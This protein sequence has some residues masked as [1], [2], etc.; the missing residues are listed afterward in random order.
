MAT[1]E[2]KKP[3]AKPKGQKPKAS[4]S[5]EDQIAKLKAE[6]EALRAGKVDKP[7]NY[8]VS[9]LNRKRKHA[10]SYN[11]SP[12]VYNNGD[13]VDP[14]HVEFIQNHVPSIKLEAE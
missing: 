6:N 12:V 8:F 7:L 11:R 1:E 14:D 13:H 4:E 2:K 10:F 5:L 3:A 9:R